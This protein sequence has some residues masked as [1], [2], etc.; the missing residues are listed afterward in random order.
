MKETN[1]ATYLDSQDGVDLV[2]TR[3]RLL[4]SAWID[5]GPGS[6]EKAEYRVGPSKCGKFDVLW[7]SSDFDDGASRNA[8]A[9]VPRHQMK[10]KALQLALLEGLFA[11]E[12]AEYDLDE[13]N[14]SEVDPASKAALTVREV[15]QVARHVFGS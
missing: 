2:P 3:T 13:P 11:A 1:I 14:F 4:F 6:S 9:W 10:G 5:H 8:A 7:I 15:G 12:K